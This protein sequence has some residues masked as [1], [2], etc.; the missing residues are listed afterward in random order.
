M[1]IWKIFLL[2]TF[3]ITLLTGCVTSRYTDPNLTIAPEF[4]ELEDTRKTMQIIIEDPEGIYVSTTKGLMSDARGGDPVEYFQELIEK[5][6]DWHIRDIS[7]L[8]K[9]EFY[10]PEDTRKYDY[11]LYLSY[12]GFYPYYIRDF[13]PGTSSFTN[14]QFISTPPSS[15][16]VNVEFDYDLIYRIEDNKTSEI[17]MFN[18]YDHNEDRIETI[19]NFSP[20]SS[21]VD[22]ASYE[23]NSGKLFAQPM[24]L[25]ANGFT[26]WVDLLN[27]NNEKRKRGEVSTKKYEYNDN[28]VLKKKE[29]KK[30][31]RDL[32]KKVILNTPFYSKEEEEKN[33][34]KYYDF[35]KKTDFH[36]KPS[37]FNL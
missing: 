18:W 22:A 30:G 1:K 21:T 12:I 14:G 8:K 6:F 4:K 31:I 7:N 17:V 10:K 25:S 16:I 37:L 33:E 23:E 34:S 15:S 36:K 24:F 19:F 28:D 11:T 13:H 29:W 9:V 2:S 20:L 35:N 3:L 5:Y 27:A 26:I 32:A